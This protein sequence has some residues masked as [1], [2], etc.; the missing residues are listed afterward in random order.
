MAFG[1]ARLLRCIGRVIM[2]GRVGRMVA[3]AGVALW[4]AV[5]GF[6]PGFSG[7]AWAS[8]RVA[9]VVGNGDYAPEIGKLKNPANDAKLMADTLK[10]LGFDVSLVVD[11]DQKG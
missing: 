1:A 10:D 4:L 3:M 5:S 11:A 9:L 7:E 8:A 6:A 2:G